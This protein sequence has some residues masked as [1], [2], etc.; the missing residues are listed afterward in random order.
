MFKREPY[1]RLC[2]IFIAFTNSNYVKRKMSNLNFG[3]SRENSFFF[4]HIYKRPCNNKKLTYNRDRLGCI[5]ITF[6]NI[7]KSIISL[8][9][10]KKNK[11]VE[12]FNKTIWN[13]SICKI[14]LIFILEFFFK[15]V[16]LLYK[17][18]S[19]LLYTHLKNFFQVSYRT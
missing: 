15:Q 8:V 19:I 12:I 5:V 13:L 16:I 4:T 18:T 9:L 3:C 7:S 17:Y 2:Q 1:L 11:R 6:F 14:K 10:V